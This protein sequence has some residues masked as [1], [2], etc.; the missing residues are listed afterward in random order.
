MAAANLAGQVVMGPLSFDVPQD[1]LQLQ[2]DLETDKLDGTL[3]KLSQTISKNAKATNSLKDEL[4]ALRAHIDNNVAKLQRS[5][6][7]LDDSSRALKEQLMRVYDEV[8]AVQSSTVK[9]HEYEVEKDLMWREHKAAQAFIEEYHQTQGHMERV[10]SW[11]REL[12]PAWYAGVSK[13]TMDAIDKRLAQ[14]IV[15][16]R[17]SVAEDIQVEAR[18]LSEANK[19][20]TAIVD[21]RISTIDARA[22]GLGDRLTDAE[23]RLGRQVAIIN[24]V[25]GAHDDLKNQIVAASNRIDDVQ[26]LGSARVDSVLALLGVSDSDLATH[27]MTTELVPSGSSSSL[28]SGKVNTTTVAASGARV[29]VKNSEEAARFVATLPAF[30]FAAT[31]AVD[32]ATTSAQQL[33][34]RLRHELETTTTQ[35]RHELADKVGLSKLKD[36]LEKNKDERLVRTVDGLVREVATLRESKVDAMRFDAAMSAKADRSALDGKADRAFVESAVALAASKADAAFAQ[37]E[38]GGSALGGSAYGGPSRQA[39]DMMSL[40]ATTGGGLQTSR[41]QQQQGSFPGSGLLTPSASHGSGHSSPRHPGLSSQQQRQHSGG[42]SFDGHHHSHHGGGGGGFAFTASA[43]GTHETGMAANTYDATRGPHASL[44]S[45]SPQNSSGHPQHHHN[46]P[47]SAPSGQQRSYQPGSLNLSSPR[48]ADGPG[49]PPLGS[50]A[51]G[52]MTPRSGRGGGNGEPDEDEEAPAVNTVISARR[53]SGRGGRGGRA[54]SAGGGNRSRGAGT[55]HHGHEGDDDDD[56]AL[57]GAR[58]AGA[59]PHGLGDVL[60]RMSADDFLYEQRGDARLK[61]TIG[62]GQHMPPGSYPPPPASGSR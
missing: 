42:G 6:S 49:R 36:L 1:Y 27:V 30:R 8:K 34:G 48:N 53:G 12:L 62:R 41:G 56:D 21:A 7:V 5:I 9:R 61:N 43:I 37:M 45:S 60:H 46:P 26:H 38:R 52:P 57:S 44:S 2:Y 14:L 50:T 13:Q 22:N 11:V 10:Q 28:T 51:G 39:G 15:D 17:A 58:G 24:A 16:V 3:V 29:A 20:F 18:K 31:T 54:G 33:C 19:D 32:A 4:S 23:N 47:G 35:V 55:A 25:S 40:S 59:L